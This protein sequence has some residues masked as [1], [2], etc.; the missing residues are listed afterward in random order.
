MLSRLARR[1]VPLGFACGVAAYL[2]ANPT[3]A[4]LAAGVAVAACGEALRIWAAGHLEKGREVTRSGPYA[5]TRHPLYV[6]S[7]VMGAG[8]AIAANDVRAAGLAVGY[9]A[10]TLTA[11]VR[12]EEAALRARFG[13]EYD[14]YRAGRAPA[15]RRRFS[16]ERARRN[17]EGRAMAGLLAAVALLA[18]KLL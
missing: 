15:A 16:L 2:L 13:S 4:T 12:T 11:A 9:L 3:A 5:W 7:A 1:R 14:A 8:F 6:G 10:V 18:A 17:R